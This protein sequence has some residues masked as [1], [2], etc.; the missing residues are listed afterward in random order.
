[1]GFLINSDSRV[2]ST[3]VKSSLLHL[4]EVVMHSDGVLYRDWSRQEPV[5]R[6]LPNMDYMYEA[7]DSPEARAL[8]PPTPFLNECEPR[9]V[10]C[11]L[12]TP[13]R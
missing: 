6:P 7:H 13:H 9:A 8:A 4:Y 5:Q 12:L 3:R 11:G 2:R 1:M 10:S